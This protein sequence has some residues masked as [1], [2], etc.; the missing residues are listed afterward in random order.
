[1]S[2]EKRTPVKTPLPCFGLE[3]VAT[4]PTCIN[5]PHQTACIYYHGSRANRIPLEKAEFRLVPRAFG[6]H[7]AEGV[8]DDPEVPE[9]Q[10]VYRR[11][12]LFRL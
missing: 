1:M 7:Y 12:L 8:F 10:R 6:E 9:M 11:L 3:Y 4:D 5:C 2:V